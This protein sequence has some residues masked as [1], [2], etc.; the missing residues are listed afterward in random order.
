VR[1][2][3]GA[4]ITLAALIVV[5]PVLATETGPPP[6][7]PLTLLVGTNSFQTG[8]AVLEL[9]ITSNGCT[10][11]AQIEGTLR[12]SQHAW[13][14]SPT[15]SNEDLPNAAAV[16]L[17]GTQI[18]RA[19]IGLGNAPDDS[20]Q[21]EPEQ[22]PYSSVHDYTIFGNP[23]DNTAHPEPVQSPD[24]STHGHPTINFRLGPE[25]HITVRSTATP[26]TGGSAHGS[27]GAS[28]AAWSAIALHAPRW[29]TVKGTLRFKLAVALVHPTGYHKCYLDIPQIV[30]SNLQSENYALHE[31][32]NHALHA[33]SGGT[34]TETYPGIDETQVGKINASVRGHLPVLSTIAADG[35]PSA[36]GVYY[37][38][39]RP[40]R[41]TGPE[42][43][44][45]EAN[46]P[47]LTSALNLDC[48]DEP[49]FETPGTTSDITRRIFFAGIL[50][51]LG[52]T[53]LIDAL[54]A[55]I[56]PAASKSAPTRS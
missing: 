6:P 25:Y 31:A 27:D 47:T 11:P 45:E 50:G 53:L 4:G 36:T 9:N 42:T 44:E 15:D 32:V 49:L 51:A 12:R 14:P 26:L 16:V 20:A 29:L 8:P 10:N 19:Q 13:A 1:L 23:P 2:I 34:A 35:K 41:E 22:S 17:V 7:P 30:Q 56:E 38:C 37:Q 46:A 40:T 3:V 43:S 54:F 5:L 33:I 39:H 24:T 48:A 55:T 52:L 21:D 28:T 18:R